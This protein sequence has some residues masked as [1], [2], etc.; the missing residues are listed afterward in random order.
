M[1][2]R[3]LRI[4]ARLGLGFGLV[5]ALMALMIL[6][7]VVRLQDIGNATH[8]MVERDLVRER[9]ASEWIGII[10]SNGARSAAVVKSNDPAVQ[11]YFKKQMA[12]YSQRAS[13]IQKQLEDS[14]TG[15]EDRKVLDAML[16]QRKVFKVPTSCEEIILSKRAFSTLR[17]LPFNGRIAWVRRLRPC[18]AEPPAESPSTR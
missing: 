18:L 5:L 11:D 2:I 9:I 1:T 13:A 7:G 10:E 6:I 17:I 4:G 16:A 3:N 15:P 14:V 12:S 8:T